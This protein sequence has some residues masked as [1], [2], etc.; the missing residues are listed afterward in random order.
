MSILPTR[1]RLSLLILL[2]STPAMAGEAAT[3][4]DP[5]GQAQ[6]DGDPVPATVLTGLPADWRRWKACACASTHR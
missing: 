3:G 2:A 4:L 1:R 6:G 5:L